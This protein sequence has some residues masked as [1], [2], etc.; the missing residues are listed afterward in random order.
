MSV[1]VRN[2][3]LIILGLVIVVGLTS[4]RLRGLIF[5]SSGPAEEAGADRRLPVEVIAIHPAMVQDRILATG[6]IIAD[7][8]VEIRSEI[9]GKIV[10]IAFREGTRIRR[11]DLLVKIDD[12][13][14]QAQA[15]KLES[16]QKLAQDK[17]NRR[18]QLRDKGNI[19]PED[20]DVALNELNAIRGEVQLIQAR[21]LKT[22]LRAP[23]DGTI[24]LRYVSEGSYVSPQTRIAS[25]QRTSS[26]KIDF[27]VPERYA[28]TVKPGQTV[29]FSVAGGEGRETG[30][31]Y[32]VEPKIDPSTRTVLIR[33]RAPNPEG[34]IAPGAF[35][36]VELVL[37]EIPEAIMIP[38]QALVPDLAGHKVYVV[39]G[40]AAAE[41]RVEIGLRTEKDVQIV[42]GLR[43]TDTVITTG[44]LQVVAGAPVR[45]TVVRQ[46]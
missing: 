37:R 19:S 7:E 44:I 1:R 5:G 24:G 23:F 27:S 46:P 15:Y 13:E 20:Y 9:S 40:G 22:E 26:L 12:S 18:R 29:Y 21:I 30:T 32:A 39:E 2:S 3:L 36:E 16:E 34:R 17:E 41:R 42:T 25:L 6:T 43:A 8:E 31:I 28:G 10:K 14:L 33:A 45:V 38:T 4:P 35:A 11:G